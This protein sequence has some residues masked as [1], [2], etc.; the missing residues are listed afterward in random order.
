MNTRPGNKWLTA[1]LVEAA[2]SVGRMKGKNYLAAQHARLTA[3]RG[4]SRAQV[5]VAHS[6]LVSAYY[7]LQRDEPYRDLGPDWLARRNEA[8][9]RRLVAQLEKLG[10]NVTLNHPA[11]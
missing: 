7:M 4:M 9:T 5:A 1:M 10:H 2:G 3:R 11:A 8:H 6:I